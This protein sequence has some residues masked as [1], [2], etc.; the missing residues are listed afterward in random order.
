MCSLTDVVVY[1]EFDVAAVFSLNIEQPLYDGLQVWAH[2]GNAMIL[3]KDTSNWSG[4]DTLKHVQLSDTDG[5]NGGHGLVRMNRCRLITT[6]IPASGGTNDVPLTLEGVGRFT[7]DSLYTLSAGDKNIVIDK[8]CGSA[9]FRGLQQEW[10]FGL[11]GAIEPWG[12]YIKD[13]TPLAGENK[14]VR[15]TIAS[16]LLYAIYGQDN[17]KVSLNVSDDTVFASQARS[18]NYIDI[19]D[20]PTA[21]LPSEALNQFTGGDLDVPPT[22]VRRVGNPSLTEV[23]TSSNSGNVIANGF[24]NLIANGKPSGWES[25]LTGVANI[26]SSVDGADCRLTITTA[27]AQSL[28]PSSASGRVRVGAGDKF[29]CSVIASTPAGGHFFTITMA[30]YDK[31]GTFIENVDSTGLTTQDHST[32]TPTP[33]R[34]TLTVPTGTTGAVTAAFRLVMFSSTTYRF[35]RYVAFRTV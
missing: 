29:A 24:F 33:Q 26:A 5:Y 20:G 14:V 11:T 12:I 17:V 2:A 16:S 21:R 13:F 1:G 19:W 15:L 6:R 23:T 35:S 8:G 18:A 7:A 32:V 31:T 4:M 3:A 27:A 9:N 22:A 10:W 28:R 25:D 34:A 30:L